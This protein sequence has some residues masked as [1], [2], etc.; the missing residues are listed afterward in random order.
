M[1]HKTI[2]TLIA[3][4]AFF[5]ATTIFVAG[6][7]AAAAATTAQ[8]AM[9]GV[10]ND[11]P[12]RDEFQQTYQLTPGA[13]VEVSVISGSVEVETSDATA[14]E[15][16]VVRTARSRADLAY[17]KVSVAR[18]ASGLVVRGEYERDGAVPRGVEVRVR[19]L[20]RIPRNVA[21]TVRTI[22]GTAT[23]GD[24]DGAV[25]LSNISGAARL[26]NVGGTLTAGNVSGPLTVGNVG[27]RVRLMNISG[28][29]TL[30]Q[31]VGHLELK[32]ISG[33]IA[34]AVARLDRRGILVSNVSGAI[35]LRFADALNADVVARRVN[36][37][38]ILNVPDVAWQGTPERTLIRARIGAGGI[39][40]SIVEVSG[41]VRFERLT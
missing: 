23:V 20:L 11:L 19:V 27:D 1:K 12:E 6:G 14:A 33:N 13:G 36:G 2:V 39:P 4:V 18:R 29:V 7:A 26:S 21:L 22:S 24:I 35:E 40:I 16:R 9:P 31:V 25:R 30:G 10:Q 17:R 8:Q 38:V 41:T 34:A 5:A 3:V 28:N 15:V 37:R 32:G